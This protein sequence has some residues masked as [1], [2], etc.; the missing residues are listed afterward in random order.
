MVCC[1]DKDTTGNGCDTEGRAHANVR[2][3]KADRL[4]VLLSINVSQPCSC[5]RAEK[6]ACSGCARGLTHLQPTQGHQLGSS[7]PSQENRTW[8]A[9]EALWASLWEVV[10]KSSQVWLIKCGRA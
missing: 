3:K 8:E 10:F 4:D 1:S 9:F 5:H 2:V 6:M 7:P